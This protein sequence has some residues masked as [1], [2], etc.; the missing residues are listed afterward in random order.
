MRRK[1]TTSTTWNSH[2]KSQTRDRKYAD[3]TW[4]I[5]GCMLS[6]LV[7]KERQE[8]T[9][10]YS[11]LKYLNNKL[12]EDFSDS[13]LS[14]ERWSRKGIFEP[15]YGDK[16]L[17]PYRQIATMPTLLD[18]VHGHKAKQTQR[19]LLHKESTLGVSKPLGIG[20]CSG[21]ELRC[22][23][24]FLLPHATSLLSAREEFHKNR[25]RKNRS[26]LFSIAGSQRDPVIG[27]PVSYIHRLSEM[28]TQECETIRQ[29]KT[30]KQKK[31]KKADS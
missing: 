15:Q 18:G 7:L 29:E 1:F 19:L 31:N 10:P 3:T 9:R 21:D 27:A 2:D 28:A 4:F 14:N 11:D 13:P 6:S 17:R 22:M 25:L 5:E 16:G 23:P 8:V 26:N 12:S 30:R 20:S 24:P